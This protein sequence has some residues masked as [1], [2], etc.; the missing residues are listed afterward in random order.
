MSSKTATYL[1]LSLFLFSSGC[2][3]DFQQK[4]AEMFERFDRK[5]KDSEIRDAPDPSIAP[6]TH[7]ASGLML[8]RQGN[9]G[10]AAEQFEKA[11]EGDPSM[12][13]GHNRLGMAHTRMGNFESAEASF[14]RA[15]ELESDAPALQNNLGFCL[16]TARKYKGAETA[17]REALKLAPDFERARMNLGIALA[18]QHRLGDAAVEFSRV[19]PAEAAYYNVGVVCLDMDDHQQAERA[20]RESLAVKPDY[21]PAIKRLASMNSRRTTPVAPKPSIAP[22][23]TPKSSQPSNV[24]VR[25]NRPIG[26]MQLAADPTADTPSP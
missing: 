14:R 26:E 18:R 21:E 15:I 20:F 16:L 10:G 23:V 24:T 19:V 1:T 2:A 17:F 25:A 13:D 5:P 9:F 4:W 3:G 12:V 22:N 7:Y 11:I 6:E 8:E